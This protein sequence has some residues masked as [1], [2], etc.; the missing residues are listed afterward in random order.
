MSARQSPRFLTG[1]DAT[2]KPRKLLPTWCF[3]KILKREKR[4]GRILVSIFPNAK[5]QGKEREKRRNAG[6]LS[7]VSTNSCLQRGRLIHAC[8]EVILG[9]QKKMKAAL[10]CWSEDGNKGCPRIQGGRKIKTNHPTKRALEVAKAA[11]VSGNAIK[12]GRAQRFRS[13]FL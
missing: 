8:S 5:S 3:S 13:L 10:K 2:N 11:Y 1:G 9:E 7:L 4:G 12:V 6:R